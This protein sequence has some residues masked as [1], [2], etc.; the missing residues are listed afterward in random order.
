M[1][2]VMPDAIVVVDGSGRIVFA[3]Q[4]VS[5][6]LGYASAELVG[7]PLGRLIPV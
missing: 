6:L 7:E 1:F 2:N 4:L 3:N 5:A